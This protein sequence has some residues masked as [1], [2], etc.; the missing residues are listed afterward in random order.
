MDHFNCIKLILNKE[1]LVVG[2]SSINRFWWGLILFDRK[3]SLVKGYLF[4]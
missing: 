1:E 2:S 3:I 4:R